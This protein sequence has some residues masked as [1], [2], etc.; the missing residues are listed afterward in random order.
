M[1]LLYSYSEDVVKFSDKSG[2]ITVALKFLLANFDLHQL[3]EST[4]SK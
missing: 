2:N 3:V 4:K 1:D